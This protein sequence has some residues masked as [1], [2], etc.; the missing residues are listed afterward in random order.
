MDLRPEDFEWVTTEI[1]R[2]ADLCCSGRVVSVLEGGYGRPSD[3]VHSANLNEN[4]AKE[5]DDVTEKS[6]LMATSTG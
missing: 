3:I 6:T 4:I 1:M 5:S 2:I